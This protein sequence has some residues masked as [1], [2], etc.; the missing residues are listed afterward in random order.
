MV[1]SLRYGSA[2]DESDKRA[3]LSELQAI[4]QDPSF[5]NDNFDP[6]IPTSEARLKE[7]LEDL[8]TMEDSLADAREFLSWDGIDLCEVESILNN[9]ESVLAVYERQLKFDGPDDKGDAIVSLHAGSGGTESQYWVDVLYRAYI[10][11]IKSKG[12][13]VEEMDITFG[14]VSGIKSVTFSVQGDLAYGHFRAERGTHRFCRVSP[15]DSSGRVHTSF[16]S[17]DVIPSVEDSDDEVEINSADLDIS[18]YK[19]SGPGGQHANKADSAVRITHAPSGITVQCQSERSQ[20]RNK[21]SAL[22]LLRSRLRDVQRREM[23]K[24]AQNR[25]ESK[26]DNAFGHQIRSYELH[27]SAYVKDHRTDMMHYQPNDVLDGDFDRLI[28]AFLMWEKN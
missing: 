19:S 1:V 13:T 20:H 2:F 22:K 8:S 12:W 15:F 10:Q 16:L 21:D 25:Y 17:V 3:R 6:D 23:E 24:D 14:S 5:W 11:Y 28:E 4:L 7:I 26:S 18:T 27:K 9:V